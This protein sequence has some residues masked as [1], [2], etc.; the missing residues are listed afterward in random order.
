MN[1]QNMKTQKRILFAFVLFAAVLIILA[2]RSGYWQIIKGNELKEMAVA[3]Q[4]SDSIVEAKRGIIY[5]RN[6][7]ELAI[8]GTVYSVW[9]RPA[10]I[11]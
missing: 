1:K 2:L 6:D 3:Q 11:A 7:M 5:D 8:S 9:L 4:T 10:A